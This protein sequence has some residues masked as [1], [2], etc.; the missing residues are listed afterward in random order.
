MTKILQHISH[1]REW[2]AEA[3]DKLRNDNMVEGELFLSLA[4]AEIHKAWE[5]SM[6]SRQQKKETLYD[7]L[8]QSNLTR[9]LM[10]IALIVI[11]V[12]VGFNYYG[13]SPAQPALELSLPREDNGLSDSISGDL[14]RGEVGLIS[15]NLSLDQ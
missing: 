12:F 1:A 2:L 3:E 13:S 10:V 14:H 5:N 15:N 6:T 4:E 9:V 8:K 11:L 7:R